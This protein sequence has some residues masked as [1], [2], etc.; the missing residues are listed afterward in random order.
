MN[1]RIHVNNITNLLLTKHQNGLIIKTIIF[2]LFVSVKNVS[3]AQNYETYYFLCNKADSLKFYEKKLEALATYKTAFQSVHFIHTNK[4]KKAYDLAI[5]TNSFQDAFDF[6]KNI[7]LNTGNQELIQTK[8]RVFRKSSYYKMMMD[9]CI[10]FQTECN[11]R[12]NHPYIKIIDSLVFVDQYIIRNNKS[13]KANYKM[14]KKKLP[15]NLFDLDSSN[16]HLLFNC[17]K[18][19]GFPSEE[20]VGYETYKKAWA[21]LHHN[22]RLIENEKYHTEIFEYIKS[23]DYLP[24]DV[25]VWYEQFQQQNYGKTF[26]TTWDGNLSDENL[27]RIEKNRRMF[28]LKGLDSYNLKKNGRYMIAKW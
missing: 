1:P 26:F 5:E 16:W 22:L 7:L 28:Y 3:F 4:L 27:A 18:K 21:I 12:I 17:I 25:L 19:W 6:G 14:D 13:Y 2:L 15:E 23:G 10:Y 9:S 24:E 20:Q 8:S 11:N